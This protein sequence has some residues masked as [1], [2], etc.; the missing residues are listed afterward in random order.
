M[1]VL[2]APMARIS[3]DQVKGRNLGR[4]REVAGRRGVARGSLLDASIAF[5][6]RSPAV[7]HANR[8]RHFE[9][10]ASGE[11]HDG[12]NRFSRVPKALSIGHQ[13]CRTCLEK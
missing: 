2:E 9:G 10:M 4:S 7:H 11:E 13:R 12:K 1:C 8:A 6:N 5:G 3:F